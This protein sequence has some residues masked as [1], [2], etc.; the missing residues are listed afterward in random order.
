MNKIRNIEQLKKEYENIST[1][2]EMR[3]FLEDQSAFRERAMKLIPEID[4]ISEVMIGVIEKTEGDNVYVALWGRAKN[5]K[6][7]VKTNRFF[8]KSYATKYGEIE[9]GI[10]VAFVIYKT[11]CAIQHKNALVPWDI[12]APKDWIPLRSDF[13]YSKF[14][15]K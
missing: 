7:L 9:E 11:E 5:E 3:L 1:K 8:R 4:Y 15:R 10:P 12:N 6:K 2:Q 14:S 13:D